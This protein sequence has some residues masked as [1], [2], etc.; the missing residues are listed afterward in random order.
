MAS[1]LETAF[2]DYLA[3]VQR[4][5]S[6]YAAVIRA[7]T[8]ALGDPSPTRR[9]S[10]IPF[11]DRMESRAEFAS[12]VRSSD[13]EY[14]ENIGELVIWEATKSNLTAFLR[15]SGLYRDALEGLPVN[16]SESAARY[17]VAMN[18][19]ED[20]VTYL[21]PIEGVEFS[22]EHLDCGDFEVTRFSPQDLDGRIQNSIRRRFFAPAYHFDSSALGDYWFVQMTS[23][24]ARKKDFDEILFDRK[25]EVTY[26]N[27][28]RVVEEA[29][30][31]LA[32]FNWHKVERFQEQDSMAKPADSPGPSLPRFPFAIRSSDSLVEWPRTS[33]DLST[34]E[35]EPDS[36]LPA[37]W[38]DLNELQTQEFEEF[39]RKTGTLLAKVNSLRGE[40][41]FLEVAMGFL[42]KALRDG[43]YGA[44][45]VE[46]S[47][48]LR[49][50][51]A[52][53]G[54]K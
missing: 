16:G 10:L 15:L 51:L 52:R 14:P 46:T 48:L 3:L 44:T 8:R 47:R 19:S 9:H 42:L 50:V 5:Y 34:L 28:P 2:Q 39:M 7:E 17:R 6:D 31:M 23:I 36:G 12:L 24:V 26:S 27:Y 25:V 49:D 38:L 18:A 30:R 11:L 43:R 35:N 22:Q 32:L 13:R 41:H 1:E 54:R 40:R 4:E 45:A 29:L 21:L 33:P 53:R 37:I 20:A